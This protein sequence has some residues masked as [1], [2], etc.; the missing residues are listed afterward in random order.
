M[1]RFSQSQILELYRAAVTCELERGALLGGIARDL[2][3]QLRQIPHPGAQ[4]LVDLYVLSEVGILPDGS[5]PLRTWLMNA[6]T[7]AEPRQEAAAFACAIGVLGTSRAPRA[8]AQKT[9]GAQTFSADEVLA[10]VTLL[11]SKLSAVPGSHPIDSPAR[12]ERSRKTRRASSGLRPPKEAQGRSKQHE[13]RKP[14]V[15]AESTGDD[16]SRSHTFMDAEFENDNYDSDD[17]GD[18]EK[19][20]VFV[21][22]PLSGQD[23]SDAYSAIKDECRKLK[24]KATRVD[25][26][27]G[28]GFI[29]KQITDLIER[30]EFLIFDLTHERPNVYYELGYAHGVGNEATDILL[31]AREGTTLHF[32]IAALRVH[33]YSSTERL[34]SIVA[35]NLKTMMKESRR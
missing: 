11:E 10:R 13:A 14:S 9:D 4:L 6:K 2:T 28:S 1:A 12:Q 17:D 23:M 3:A 27:S 7:L 30:A 8:H 32:D 22:M 15:S 34:R 21:A 31:L 33:Y 18:F 26:G 5:D 29:I 25:D 16:M 24:L 20:L 19:N 35:T